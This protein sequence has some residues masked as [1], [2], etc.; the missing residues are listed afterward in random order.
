MYN[1]VIVKAITI[2]QAYMPQS[3]IPILVAPTNQTRSA[4]AK[5]SP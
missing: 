3:Y 1:I 2:A 4:Q 5:D